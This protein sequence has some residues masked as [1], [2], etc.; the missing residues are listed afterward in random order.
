MI[1][2]LIAWKVSYKLNHLIEIQETG[3][4]IS[5]ETRITC[6]NPSIIISLQYTQHYIQQYIQSIKFGSQVESSGI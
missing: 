4:S 1:H 3:K 6:L 5:L 2:Q